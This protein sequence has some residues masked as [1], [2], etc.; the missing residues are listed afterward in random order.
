M[1]HDPSREIGFLS[2]A[3]RR[4]RIGSFEELPATLKNIANDYYRVCMLLP[5]L[6]AYDYFLRLDRW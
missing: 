6:L 2:T 3:G 4:Q 5:S 1:S